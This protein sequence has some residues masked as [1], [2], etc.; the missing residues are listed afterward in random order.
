MALASN[1][2]IGILLYTNYQ[3][4]IRIESMVGKVLT[5]REELESNLRGMIVTLQQEF[6]ALP[7]LF[8]SDPKKTI[9]D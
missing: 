1:F 9:L 4:T 3:S 6:M 8:S 7:Q 2:F 5:I